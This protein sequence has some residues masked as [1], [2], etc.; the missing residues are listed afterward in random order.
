VLFMLDEMAAIGRLDPLLNA[1]GLLAGSGMQLHPIFQDF[2]QIHRTYGESW[3]T[4]IANAAVIQAFGTRDHFTADMVS[5]LCGLGTVESLSVDTALARAAMLADPD[6]FTRQDHQVARP[7]ITPG[8]MM[9]LHPTVQVLLLANAWP[10]PAYKVP[11]FL[12]ARYRNVDSTPQFDLPPRYAKRSLPRAVE[13]DWPGLD[14]FKT[15]NPFLN[16]G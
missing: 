1:F 7:L 3:Q 2:T 9:T 16:V 8:E 12:D 11:Y 15:L 14:L 10:A 6:Y 13:F 5:K 4:F